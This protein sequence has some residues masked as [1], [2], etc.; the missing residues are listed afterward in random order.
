[1]NFLQKSVNYRFITYSD[2][3]INISPLPFYT[4]SSSPFSI[5]FNSLSDKRLQTQHDLSWVNPQ[6]ASWAVR[7][8]ISSWWY[9]SRST[10]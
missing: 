10:K 4:Y 3:L 8:M 9:W 5:S 1:M 6:C 7:L 2:S